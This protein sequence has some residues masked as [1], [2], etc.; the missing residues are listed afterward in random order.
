MSA[1]PHNAFFVFFRRE[2]LEFFWGGCY[3]E[4]NYTMGARLAVG[5]RVKVD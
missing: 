2:A 4:S 3:L 1:F 5:F